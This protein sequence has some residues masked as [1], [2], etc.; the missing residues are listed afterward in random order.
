MKPEELP[1]LFIPLKTE[2][3]EAFESGLKTDE[4][5][6]YGPR[7]NELTCVPGRAVV[8][9]KGYGKKSRLRGRIKYFNKFDPWGYGDND[10]A[11]ILACFGTL[12]K[13]IAHITIELEGKHHG[14]TIT[15]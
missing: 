12:D 8:L 11:A 4:L 7:W 3:F 6:L 1:A 13:P 14:R 9:S 5:R 10:R 15:P 2:Y